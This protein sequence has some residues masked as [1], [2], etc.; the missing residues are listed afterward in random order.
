M[1]E[2]NSIPW[3]SGYTGLGGGTPLGSSLHP[4]KARFIL[5]VSSLSYESLI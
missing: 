1:I 4:G 2:C 3:V 5:S